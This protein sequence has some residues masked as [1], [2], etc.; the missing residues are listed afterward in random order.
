MTPAIKGRHYFSGRPSDHA[1]RALSQKYHRRVAVDL[2][3]RRG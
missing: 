2:R 3:R 1:L